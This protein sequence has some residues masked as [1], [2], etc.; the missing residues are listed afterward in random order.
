[1]MATTASVLYAWLAL[2]IVRRSLQLSL[3]R[4]RGA[5]DGIPMYV[6]YGVVLQL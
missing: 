5:N 4:R 1:M 3:S 2:L 6:I